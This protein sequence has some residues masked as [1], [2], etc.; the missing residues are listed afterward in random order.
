[1]EI[2]IGANPG[3]IE[4]WCY[5]NFKIGDKVKV[6]KMCSGCKP[7]EV[8]TLQKGSNHGSNSNRLFAVKPGISGCG[9]SCTHNWIEPNEFKIGD[10]V[11]CLDGSA[12]G[13]VRHKEGNITELNIDCTAR[14]NGITVHSVDWDE[15]GM[16]NVRQTNLQKVG[17]DMNLRKRIEALDDGWNKEADDILQEI[18]GKTEDNYMFLICGNTGKGTSSL[19]VF[20]N[21][22]E[23]DRNNSVFEKY[24]KDQCS[25]NTAFTDALLWLLDKSGLD[26]HK[27]GD[28]I[29]ISS[30]GKMYE[31]KILKKL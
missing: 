29:Q 14:T 23:Y 1:M 18:V 24:F 10:R 27:E 8:Y 9:C 7:G 25:K 22:T 11:K 21:W 4:R 12:P 15:Y 17:V 6:E 3:T 28:K 20:K 19:K 16:W 26:G 30:E 5:M 13:G 31:V 2:V